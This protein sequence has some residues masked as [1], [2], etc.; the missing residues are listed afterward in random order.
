M[1]GG[2]LPVIDGEEGVVDDMQKRMANSGVAS[3][4]SIACCRRGK[5]RLEVGSGIGRSWR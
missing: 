3:R 2:E 5:R 4:W 1:N